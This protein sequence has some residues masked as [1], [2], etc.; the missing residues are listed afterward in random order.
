MSGDYITSFR[1][2]VIT[3]ASAGGKSTLTNGLLGALRNARLL[4]SVTTRQPR[5]TDLE[6]EYEYVSKEEFDR[7]L[8]QDEFFSHVKVFDDY[9]GVKKS[10]LASALSNNDVFIRPLTPDK[11]ALWYE[12]G[13]EKIVF[14]HLVP[15]PPFEVRARMEARGTPALE[16][17]AR[18]QKAQEWEAQIIRLIADGVPI[19]FVTGDTPANMLENALRI[20]QAL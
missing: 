6:G 3:G 19:R 14:L 15:P 9:Y 1:I 16:I 7:V 12:H 20:L 18:L 10:S 17:I 5:E 13:K 11:V 2:V 8:A 4:A